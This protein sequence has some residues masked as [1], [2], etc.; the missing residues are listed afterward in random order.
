MKRLIIILVGIFTNMLS[1][2][3]GRIIMACCP[4]A[5]C[6]DAELRYHFPEYCASNPI[7]KADRPWEFNAMGDPYA[8]PFSG[9]VWYDEEVSKFKM[10]YSAGGGKRDGLLLCYAESDDGRNWNKPELDVVQGT[11]IVDTTEHDCVSVL[12]D[13]HEKIAYRRYKMF[14]VAFDSPSSVRMMLKYSTDGIH[15]SE[16]QAV[17]EH[18]Y[19][20]CAVYYDPFRCKYVLSLKTIHETYRRARCYLAHENP[21]TLVRLARRVRN[22]QEDE[23]IR[24]WFNADD[25]DPHHPDFPEIRP[26]IYN[27]EAIAY[28]RFLLG[29]FT[30]WQGP[31]NDVCDSLKIQKRNEVLLGWSDNGFDWLRDCRRPFLT[32]GDNPDA[33]NAGNVQSTSGSPL[34][35]GDS[36]YFYFSGRYNSKPEHD[37]NFAT[38]LATLRRDGFASVCAGLG[39]GW[40]TTHPFVCDG[41]YLFVNIDSRDSVCAEIL[42]ENNFPIAGF[43][44]DD[45]IP[46]GAAN[47]TRHRIMWKQADNLSSLV[48]SKI[49]VR[50]YLKDAELYSFW[51]SPS[52]NGESRGYTAGGGPGLDKTGK[53]I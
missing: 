18:I 39:E 51:F 4:M 41:E 30:I 20:R 14:I 9:G 52:V 28:E 11:N 44:K 46:T 40:I 37:S 36:L 32:V 53:D 7:L 45:C 15:W 17:S 23:H 3:Q 21:E 35:V 50:F 47:A 49:R 43:T 27:H 10:W 38:G 26:Q 33:W 19:D 1:F 12:L 25:A 24:Y 6:V 34:I 29:E 42:D 16:P 31:E 8:A 13:K 48:G 5:E 2:G 22:S